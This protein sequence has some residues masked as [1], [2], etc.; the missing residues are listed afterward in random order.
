[1][2]AKMRAQISLE[3]LITL[4]ISFAVFALLLGGM[5]Q[6]RGAYSASSNLIS[7]DFSSSYASAASFQN[8]SPCFWYN[9]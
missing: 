8:Q 3:V 5:L 2:G 1:M 6:L 9:V 7:A 4:A